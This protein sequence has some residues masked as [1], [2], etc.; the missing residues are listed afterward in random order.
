MTSLMRSACLEGYVPLALSAG[1]APYEMLEAAGIRRAWLCRPDIK[2]STDAFRRL[3]AASVEASGC[4]DFGLRLAA[5]RSLSVLGPLALLA[6]EQPS[7]RQGIQT[8]A[9]HVQLHAEA[10]RL[11]VE[12][13]QAETRLT[14]DFIAS[15]TNA[16][17]AAA[18][19]LAIGALYRMIEQ[20]LPHVQKPKA[21]HFV[22]AAS[23]AGSSYREF[24]GIQPRFHG[25]F[26]GLVYAS[27]ALDAP[28]VADATMEAYA[29]ELIAGLDAG[30][31]KSK[32]TDRVRELVVT[33]V[34]TGSC[35]LQH[36][37]EILGVSVR[38]VRRRLSE[39]GTAY[40]AVLSGVRR[41]LAS[42]YV[43]QPERSLSEVALLLGFS[44]SSRFSN[45]FRN[46]FGCSASLWRKRTLSSAA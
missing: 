5:T 23:A 6:R 43:A 46:E 14:I 22:H 45:W 1:L 15:P 17:C 37:A 41:N 35:S 36:I 7:A 38:T 44:G 10:L 29:R 25:D 28:R 42:R 20:M 21:V 39:E 31:A 19:E 40:E 16:P 32:F 26:D 4:R 2:F 12:D 27:S 33:L 13:H 8:I 9:K 3:L 18:V 30:S 11:R 24:F 34:P